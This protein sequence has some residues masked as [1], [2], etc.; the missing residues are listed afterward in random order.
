MKLNCTFP[1]QK[2]CGVKKLGRSN[3]GS[4]G[5]AV[6]LVKIS[7]ALTLPSPFPEV[8]KLAAT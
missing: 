1:K 4:K 5:E 3:S 8:E 7:L 6:L 2:R